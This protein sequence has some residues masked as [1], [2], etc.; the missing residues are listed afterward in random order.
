MFLSFD[1]AHGT[2]LLPVSK[3]KEEQRGVHKAKTDSGGPMRLNTGDIHVTKS[4]LPRWPGPRLPAA[5][6]SCSSPL[7]IEGSL[8]GVH[9]LMD[10]TN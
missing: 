7:G 10:T 3:R 5:K 1:V 9:L 2:P 6:I 4:R 8:G